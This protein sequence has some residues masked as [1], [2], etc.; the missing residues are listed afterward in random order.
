VNRGGR[1][2]LR[3]TIAAKVGGWDRREAS[4]AEASTPNSESFREDEWRPGARQREHEDEHED[5][6][7][8]EG[9]LRRLGTALKSRGVSTYPVS[10]R[11]MTGGMMYF[12]RM[13]DKIRL[14]AR[15]ELGED[16]QPNLGRARTADGACTNFLRVKY[17]ELRER[18][19]AGGSDEEILE[20]CYE[21]GRRLNR[22][23]LVVWNGFLSKLGWNDFATPT[24]EEHKQ[25]G[26]MTH[27]TDIVT[28]PDL[29]DLDEGRRS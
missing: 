22:G 21:Q 23:D 19:L 1:N 17:E 27:R 8:H 12:P 2:D 6:D 10:P 3:V 4:F 24:L 20:W 26:G 13:L 7:E 11:E 29:I 5:E 14:H 25:T 9:K 18:V 28:L 15:G 16:Y